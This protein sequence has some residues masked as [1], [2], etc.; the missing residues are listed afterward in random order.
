MRYFMLLL[1]FSL[2]LHAAR[3]DVPPEFPAF[4]HRVQIN[5]SNIMWPNRVFL[6]WQISDGSW[7]CIY[8]TKE[9]VRAAMIRNMDSML[10]PTGSGATTWRDVNLMLYI[11]TANLG[12]FEKSWCFSWLPQ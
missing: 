10:A 8:D 7:W 3:A 2:P 4:A 9:N 5:T 1:L 12:V 6:R 11:G